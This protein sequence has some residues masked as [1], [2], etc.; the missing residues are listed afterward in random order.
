MFSFGKIWKE[1]CIKRVHFQFTAKIYYDSLS[2]NETE[3]F[4]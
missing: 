1:N 2:V 3:R 4:K